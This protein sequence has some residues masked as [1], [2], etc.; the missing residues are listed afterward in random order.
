M[1]KTPRFE[2]NAILLAILLLMPLGIAG[3]T[4]A[5]AVTFTPMT[6]DLDAQEGG[7]SRSFNIIDYDGDG[8]LDIFISNGP[9]AGQ[10][11]FLYRNLGLAT[12]V[13]ITGDPLVS[14]AQSSDG[15][16]WADFDNDGDLDVFTATWWG[17]NNLL[18]TNDGDGTFTQVTTGPIVTVATFSEAG[19]WADYDQDGHLDLFVCNSAGSLKNPLYRNNGDGTF[20]G[21]TTGPLVNDLAK[22]RVGVW[23][24]Y[25]NDGD[26]DVFVA[27]EANQANGL[28]QNQGDGTF[29]RILTG[30]IFT[31]GGD[32]YGASWGDIDNDED[33]D[34]FVANNGNEDNFLYSNNG[35]GTFT[36]ITTDPVV[37]DG[38]WSVGS[39]FGDV[40]ND[41][42][43]DL[44]VANAFGPNNIVNFLYLNNGDGT[45]A[46]VTTGS[47]VT[48]T[49]W[50]YGC[51]M[52]DVDADG[53]LDIGV[54]KCLG[55][56][57]PDV[58]YLNDGNANH[59]LSVTCVGV[60][61]NRSA[62]GA[63]VRIK[64]TIDGSPRWQMR[65]I[66]SQSGYSGQNSLD[67]WFGLGDAAVAESLVVVWPSGLQRAFAN[68]TAD[69]YLTIEE[70][71]AGDDPDA[72]GWGA[73]CDNCPTDA[74]PDQFDT[75][76]DGIGDLCDNC[77]IMFNP[78]QSDT[79]GNGVGDVCDCLCP[80]Q[81][82]FDASLAVDAVDLAE[83]IDLVFFGGDEPQDPLCPVGRGDFDCTG[84][85]DAVD[86][87]QMIDHVFF[88]QAG[89]CDPCAP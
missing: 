24:D 84:L 51:A 78:G 12:F 42:D 89:P 74:N 25:D 7:D 33:F 57:E 53:D 65:E 69:Q 31:D 16:T 60:R 8:L 54:A 73:P 46:K 63:R 4:A 3:T 81:A 43:L 52:G 55:A 30:A 68:V 41:G 67:A 22:S 79:N 59:W 40:D 62:I 39:S 9:Q 2:S 83:L 1:S 34:L 28:Y 10:V 13:P 49:G 77:P 36:K 15:A 88:G 70:C 50:A 26:P 32:S 37:T 38:G 64:A 20:T 45:F 80:L 48:N 18:F 29:V 19:S 82:D 58:L 23:A 11:D 72:D 5:G 56:N 47:V 86:L 21:V 44:F 66:T 17:Q 76:L 61:S 35:D 87:A 71:D 14:V 27:N 85:S 75:D 6:I